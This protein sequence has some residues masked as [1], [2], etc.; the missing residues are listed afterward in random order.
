MPQ[1]INFSRCEVYL[2]PWGHR[3]SVNPRCTSRQTVQTH[4]KREVHD[5]LV[6]RYSSP[7]DRGTETRCSRAGRAT[8]EL[9]VTHIHVALSYRSS[10]TNENQTPKTMKLKSP[11]YSTRAFFR[12]R[13]SSLVSARHMNVPGNKLS[14]F[15]RWLKWLRTI[16]WVET[17][18][19]RIFCFCNRFF[20][21]V[22]R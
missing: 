2:R 19:G 6:N 14:T 15:E 4:Y 9:P 16:D 12:I 17:S 7:P 3:W 8:G 11:S 10:S 21:S 20:S 22:A 18:Y 13:F 1:E 5:L